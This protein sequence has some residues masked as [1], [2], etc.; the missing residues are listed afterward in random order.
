MINLSKMSE[1][2]KECMFYRGVN[3]AE[4]AEKTNMARSTICEIARGSFP[5]ATKTLIKLCEFFECSA[6]YL[7]GIDDEIRTEE[8]LTPTQSTGDRLREIMKLK[9]VTQYSLINDHGFSSSQL[10]AWLNSERLPS[11]VNLEKLSECLDVSIDC[12]LCRNK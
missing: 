12:L 10:H 8:S 6:D 7:L 4:L 5:P 9:K 1:R 3:G 2:V 11:V